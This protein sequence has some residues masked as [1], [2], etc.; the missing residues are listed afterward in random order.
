MEVKDRKIQIHLMKSK[1]SNKRG[2][3]KNKL[4]KRKKG[5]NKQKDSRKINQIIHLNLKQNRVSEAIQIILL[6]RKKVSNNPLRV[7]KFLRT[8]IQKPQV[9][10]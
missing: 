2:D 10:K 3:I 8:T 4:D 6:P 7:V 5:K 1:K 9:E